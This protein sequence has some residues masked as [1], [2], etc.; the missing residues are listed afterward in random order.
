MWEYC[1][2]DGHSLIDKR[3]AEN[4]LNEMGRLNWELVGF[5]VDRGTPYFVF[6]R[7]L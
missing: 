7:P 4:I 2:K 5:S 1:I 6:K 3:N